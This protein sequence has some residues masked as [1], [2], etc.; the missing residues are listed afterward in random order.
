MPKRLNKALNEAMVSQKT[1]KKKRKRLV[2]NIVLPPPPFVPKTLTELV[3]LAKLSKLK[4]YK[5]CQKLGACFEHLKKIDALVGMKSAKAFILDRMLS[6]LQKDQ[7]QG[8]NPVYL[9]HLVISAKPGSGKTTLVQ[10]LAKL[11]AAVGDNRKANIVYATPDMMI[12]KFLGHTVAQTVNVIKSAYGGVL[13]IDEFQSFS[14]GRNSNSSDPFSKQCLDTL[15][16]E[17]DRNGDKFMVIAAG[18]EQEMKRDVFPINPGL[19]RRFDTWLKLEKYSPAELQQIFL[20]K[21]TQTGLSYEDD[22]AE[23]TFPFFTDKKNEKVFESAGGAMEVLANKTKAIHMRTMFGKNAIQKGIVSISDM[24]EAF[25]ILQKNY[26][27]PKDNSYLISMY[28]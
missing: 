24:S 9:R 3:E 19:Q 26:D 6:L 25:E 10:L 13:L 5:D 14:D 22:F 8:D 20:L 16:R 1:E 4:N 2:K 27:Q 15:V 12:G 11:F 18:Y 23:K 21:L 28:Q 7:I 17:M